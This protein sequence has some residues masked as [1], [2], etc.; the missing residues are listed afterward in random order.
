[1]ISP[2][3]LSLLTRTTSYI[4]ASRIPDAMTS[5]PET[6][7]IN[8]VLKVFVSSYYSSDPKS[9]SLPTAFS[10]DCFTPCIPAPVFPLT[11]GI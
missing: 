11:P 5:G 1:M 2:I 6:F 9:M 10:T 4:L 8:P 7:L 3:S